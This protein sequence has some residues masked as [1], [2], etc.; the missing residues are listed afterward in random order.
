[1]KP[2]SL[3]TGPFTCDN[4]S[5]YL[6]LDAEAPVNS[7]YTTLEEALTAG[8]IVVHETGND[9]V[10]S[11]AFSPDGML[12]ASAGTQQ[13]QDHGSDQAVGHHCREGTWRIYRAHAG[14]SNPGQCRN[15]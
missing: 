9:W 15:R 8:R 1:M 10:C 12:M 4:L 2:T 5:L 3:I 13:Q 11:V 14:Q 7:P 6:V